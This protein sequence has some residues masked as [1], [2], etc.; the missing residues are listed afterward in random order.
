MSIAASVSNSGLNSAVEEIDAA[1]EAEVDHVI[2]EDIV[3]RAIAIVEAIQFLVR[4][5]EEFADFRQFVPGGGHGEFAPVLLHESRLLVRVFKEI[6]AIGEHADSD[7]RGYADP[8]LFRH[9]H[10]AEGAGGEVF[11]MRI[12]RRRQIEAVQLFQ[13]AQRRQRARPAILDKHDVEVIAAGRAG[14][15]NARQHIAMRRVFVDQG[16]ARGLFIQGIKDLV[17]ISQDRHHL[18]VEDAQFLAFPGAR[19]RLRVGQRDR[20]LRRNQRQEQSSQNEHEQ[21]RFDVSHLINSFNDKSYWSCELMLSQSFYS[22][23]LS[24][25]EAEQTSRPSGRAGLPLNANAVV[26]VTRQVAA[27]NKTQTT[28][29]CRQ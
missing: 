17:L 11:R 21:N 24:T 19:A 14:R 4:S 18:G 2:E 29:A 25:P 13:A 28:G 6:G 5:G 12:A 15:L 3:G 27:V 20:I 8:F 26:I 23:C 9:R 1:R 10:G 16:D 22:C 7:Q